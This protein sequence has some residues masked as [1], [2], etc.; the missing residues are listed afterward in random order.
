LER[1][2]HTVGELN[3]FFMWMYLCI[4]MLPYIVVANFLK[5]V[6]RTFIYRYKI[7]IKIHTYTHLWRWML[8]WMN[9]T[10]NRVNGLE[11][12]RTYSDFVVAVKNQW[13]KNTTIQRFF[14]SC[15]INDGFIMNGKTWAEHVFVQNPCNVLICVTIDILRV[16]IR[17]LIGFSNF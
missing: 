9:R 13:P 4:Y 17:N 14:L 15:A 2:I 11:N 12:L 7:A 5:H 3:Q 6:I 8:D 10:Q 16:P 1:A